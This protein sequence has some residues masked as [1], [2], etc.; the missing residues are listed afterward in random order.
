MR[1]D[2]HM[3]PIHDD[4]FDENGVLR[5]GRRVL[6][7]MK[8]MDS[9]A[10]PRPACGPLITALDGGT[11]GLHR[12]GFRIETGGN[13]GDQLVRDGARAEIQR[14]HDG[15]RQYLENAWRD[16]LTGDDEHEHRERDEYAAYDAWIARQWRAV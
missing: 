11:A 2:K 13:R 7:T 8:A 10:F 3:R 9:A 5:D 6:V 14:A 15:Y 1:K 4:D 16:P 12:P